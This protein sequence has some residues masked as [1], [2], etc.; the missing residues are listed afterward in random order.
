MFLE[1]NVSK[2]GMI[3][4]LAKDDD[5]IARSSNNPEGNIILV[6]ERCC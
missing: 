2:G 1:E 6:V 4:P 5:E 3:I